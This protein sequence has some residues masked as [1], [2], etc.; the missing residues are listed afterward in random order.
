ML[1]QLLVRVEPLASGIARI[2]ELRVALLL[3]R[4]IAALEREQFVKPQLRQTASRIVRRSD[5]DPIAEP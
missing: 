3:E 1:D 4:P 5:L 2:R